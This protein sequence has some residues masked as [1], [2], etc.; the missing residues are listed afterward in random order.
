MS[1]SVGMIYTGVGSRKDD[2]FGVGFGYLKANTDVFVSPEDT[3]WVVEAFYK[4]AAANGKF[5]ITPSVQYI[6][7][8]AGGSFIDD[9]LWILSIRFY[10]PF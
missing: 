3:E 10:V 1:A 2:Q 7:D 9:S 8:P 4:Y 5:Q 6:S